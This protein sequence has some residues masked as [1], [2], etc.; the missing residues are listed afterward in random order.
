M[1]ISCVKDGRRHHRHVSHH[2]T[3]R[4]QSLMEMKMDAKLVAA[5]MMA[6]P[7]V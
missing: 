3:N 2:L 5:D 4:H 6:A 1:N 7:R